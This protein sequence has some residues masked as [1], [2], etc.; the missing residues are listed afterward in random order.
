MVYAYEYLVDIYPWESRSPLD[1]TVGI[2]AHYKLYALRLPRT[3]AI[4]FPSGDRLTDS[5]FSLLLD[6]V[7]LKKFRFL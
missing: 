2:S 7:V 4:Y 1:A 6:E 5:N 3:A